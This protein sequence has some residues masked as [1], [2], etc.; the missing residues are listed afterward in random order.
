MSYEAF[1]RRKFADFLRENFRSPEH[2]AVCFGVTAR[3]AQNW[4]DE[5]SGPRG[6]IVAKAMTDPSM[7]ASAMRHL[8]G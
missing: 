6:H 5:T 3:Q 8:G 4:L 7:A 1:F 2:I